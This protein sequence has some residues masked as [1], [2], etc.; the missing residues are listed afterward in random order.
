MGPLLLLLSCLFFRNK[1][2]MVNA[3]VLPIN[4]ASTNNDLHWIQNLPATYAY[5]LTHHALATECIT[6]GCMAGLGDYLAQKSTQREQRKK[7]IASAADT[8]SKSP[9][10]SILPPQSSL[11]VRRLLTFIVKGLGEGVM[12]SV[13]YHQAE[14]FVTHL[15]KG[16]VSSSSTAV[17]QGT[18][19]P[20]YVALKT[21]ISVAL[22]L[23][24]A[25]PIIYAFWDI[26][27][28]SFVQGK[29]FAQI[30]HQVRIKLPTLL[31]ASVKLWMPVNILI[32]N[33]PLQY[34]VI[35]MS[36]ADIVW[37]FLVSTTIN[38][39]SSIADGSISSGGGGGDNTAA[40]AV[41]AADTTETVNLLSKK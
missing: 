1:M 27:F 2:V 11:D 31:K 40:S 32:Y 34:R 4:A 14:Y 39:V 24:I 28:P 13:W 30:C 6:A 35:L 37:Q 23:C 12:W 9:E 3:F 8:S 18:S 17:S 41:T 19:S 20:L 10:L 21:A 29:S 5:C 22:D 26:P 7:A 38:A 36:T 33:A 16:L 15:L 25:C